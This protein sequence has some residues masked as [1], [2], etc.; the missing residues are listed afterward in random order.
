MMW[1]GRRFAARAVP[2]FA[3][4]LG[5]DPNQPAARAFLQNF[6]RSRWVRLVAAR[7][8]RRTNVRAG[9]RIAI[10]AIIFLMIARLNELK[11]SATSTNAPGPPIT[12]S[13]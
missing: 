2:G 10:S 11:L 7:P 13:P 3:L 1:L 5:Y 4:L 6:T 12:F 9:D 8:Q